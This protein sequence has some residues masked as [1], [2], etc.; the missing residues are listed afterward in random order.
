M[1]PLKDIAND[2]CWVYSEGEY[3]EKLY[4]ET[5]GYENESHKPPEW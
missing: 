3:E 5:D 2:T 1:T 4:K